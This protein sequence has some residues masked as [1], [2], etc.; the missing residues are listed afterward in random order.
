LSKFQNANKEVVAMTVKEWLLDE[1]LAVY[2]DINSDETNFNFTFKQGHICMNVAFYKKCKDSLIVGGK[3]VFEPQEQSMIRYSRTKKEL[4]YDI[5]KLFI[6]MNLD[7]FLKSNVKN[8][9]FTIEGIILQKTIYFD[10]LS[11][12]K[13]FEVIS[14]IY[15]CFKVLVSSKLM[16]LGSLQQQQR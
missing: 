4:L 13:F 3:L 12:D 11:K 1:E 7:Y 15:N 16:L 2:N 14:L 9:E 8:G 10:G 6:Q 5:E